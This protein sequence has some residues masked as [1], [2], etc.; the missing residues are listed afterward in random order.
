[1]QFALEGV[2]FDA[3]VEPEALYFGGVIAT[4]EDGMSC[5]F[6]VE[7]YQYEVTPASAIIA[8]KAFLAEVAS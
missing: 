4:R 5:T 6:M 7:D 2:R 3:Y 1:M 8:A